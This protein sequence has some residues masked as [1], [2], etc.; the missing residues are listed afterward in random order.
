M[1]KS[2]LVSLEKLEP[3]FNPRSVAIAG[4]SGRII[5]PYVYDVTTAPMVYLLTYGYKGQ[6]FPINPKYEEIRGYKCYPSIS[7]IPEEVDVAIVL[8]PANTV[9]DF[10]KECGKKGVKGVVV[11]SSGFAETGDEGKL[12]QDNIREV[13]EKHNMVVLGPNCNGFINVSKGIPVTFTPVVD[14][15]KLVPGEIAFISGSGA[16]LSGIAQ[17]AKEWGMQFSYLVGTGNSAQLDEADCIRY[18]IEDPAT[19]VVMTMIEGFK[20]GSKFLDVADLALKKK[21]PIVALKVGLSE[22]GAKMAASHTG[23]LAGS[24]KVNLAAFKQKG[25]LMVEEIND[26]ILSAQIFT[27]TSLPEGD[28]IGVLSSSGGSAGLAVDLIEKEGLR[29]GELS[30]ESH[31][32]LSDTIRWFATAKNPFDFAG[33]FLRDE[34]FV[35]KVCDIFLNDPDISVLVM[36]MTALQAHEPVIL[37]QMI[38]AQQRHKKPVV[39]LYECGELTPEMDKMV[40]DSNISFITSPKECF[41]VVGNLIRYSQFLK[42]AKEVA[43]VV[44]IPAGASDKALDV[45]RTA[46]GH[47]MERESKEIIAHYGI[48]VTGQ[49]LATSLGEAQAAV[50]YI[51]YPVVLKI[52]SPDILHKSEFGGVALNINN[53]KELK[54]AYEAMLKKVKSV[55][56]KAKIRGVL[57]QEMARGDGVEVIVGVTRDPQFGPTLMF[58]LG[59]VFVELLQDV[60]FRICPITLTDAKEM[61]RETKGFKL[62]EGFRG[63]LRADIAALEEVMVKFSRLAMDLESQVKETEINPLL[64]LPEGKGVKALDARVVLG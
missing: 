44:D 58:G 3:L 49:K 30:P 32:E 62:L 26:F 27:Q 64:I 41:K 28:G 34:T 9:I 42:R 55:A 24:A 13:A 38:E 5:E 8:L 37:K 47:V 29:V 2:D 23:K 7:A 53:D 21:K 35:P 17:R 50:K 15:P 56:P 54:D 19:K 10:L 39:I 46:G 14:Q 1:S 45:I 60:S 4:A 59:G 25:V 11:T 63:S 52:D 6:I 43:P 20:N 57:V 33:Q 48:P 61:I 31:K 22:A 36:V 51:G 40:K 18:A 12:N 16:T